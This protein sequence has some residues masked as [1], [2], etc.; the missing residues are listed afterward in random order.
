MVE[1]TVPSRPYPD[2]TVCI[3][4]TNRLNVLIRKFF[5]SDIP[6]KFIKIRR[7]RKLYTKFKEIFTKYILK[8]HINNVISFPSYVPRSFYIS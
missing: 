4:P 2:R 7:P 8:G 3:N 6:K 1:T 5:L